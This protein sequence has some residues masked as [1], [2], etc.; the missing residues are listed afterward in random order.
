MQK[1]KEHM[2]AEHDKEVHRLK[3]ALQTR[4]VALAEVTSEHSRAIVALKA[5]HEEEAQTL[6]E[7]ARA[8]PMKLLEQAAKHSR[9]LTDV[10]T[11]NQRAAKR[12]TE[13]LRA[14]LNWH[15]VFHELI[16]TFDMNDLE[17]RQARMLAAH[18]LEAPSASG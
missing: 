11:A 17:A 16:E 5:E 18:D 4:K 10:R 9:K 15:R 3:E 8:Q 12:Q 6:K 13:S 7:R 14:E 2:Q 1:L